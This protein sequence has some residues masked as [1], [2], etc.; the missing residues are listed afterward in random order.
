MR[1]TI[2]KYRGYAEFCFD[3]AAHTADV[4]QRRLFEAMAKEWRRVAEAYEGLMLRISQSAD[5][6]DR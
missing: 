6:C 2:T 1:D 5:P 4:K 3:L